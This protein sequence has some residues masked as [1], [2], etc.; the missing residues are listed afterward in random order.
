MTN[1]PRNDEKAVVETQERNA[2]LLRD[3]R[4]ALEDIVA[5]VDD[6]SG[7]RSTNG[8]KDIQTIY[9]IGEIAGSVLGDNDDGDGD[10]SRDEQCE[11]VGR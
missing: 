3:Y 9:G 10:P 6:W 5:V 4:A 7:D 11:G 8:H 2:R 1:T